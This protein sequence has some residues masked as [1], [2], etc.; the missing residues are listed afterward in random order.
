[1]QVP[2]TNTAVNDDMIT[3]DADKVS[4]LEEHLTAKCKEVVNPFLEVG[5]SKYGER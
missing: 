5:S 1:M 4:W 2:S 3:V